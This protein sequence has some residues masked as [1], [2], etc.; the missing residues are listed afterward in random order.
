MDVVRPT[1][2]ACAADTEETHGMCG[3]G[4]TEICSLLQTLRRILGQKYW[5]CHW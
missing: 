5:T 1:S 4:V 2:L 3:S